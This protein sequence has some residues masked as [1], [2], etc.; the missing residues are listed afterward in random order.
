MK[1]ANRSWDRGNSPRISNRWISTKFKLLLTYKVRL[2]APRP[3]PG[4]DAW[5]SFVHLQSIWHASI[6]LPSSHRQRS[7][8]AHIAAWRRTST[9]SRRSAISS[10]PPGASPRPGELRPATYETIFGLIAATGLRLS[11][12]LNLR[13][14]EVDLEEGILTIRNTKFRKSRHVPVHA[15]VVAALDRYMAA[16]ARHGA[17]N[18]DAAILVVVVGRAVADKNHP[19]GVSEAP[20]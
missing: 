4:H 18:R 20:R 15:T 12:A 19:L 2:S 10:P 8:A 3:F 9:R 16:R 13:C 11:E 7:L 1:A 17:I 5:M 14:G 6:R